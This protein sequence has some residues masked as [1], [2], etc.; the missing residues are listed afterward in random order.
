MRWILFAISIVGLG[1]IFSAHSTTA[2][3]LGIIL[4]AVGVVGS[5]LAL[6][7]SRIGN[8]SRSDTLLL[9]DREVAAIRA[10]T[11]KAR[12]E[13][14]RAAQQSNADGKSSASRADP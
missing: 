1:L 14:L 4:A 2:V 10:A 12:A 5:F 9:A 11:L 6:L 13:S 7:D 8:N 3:W